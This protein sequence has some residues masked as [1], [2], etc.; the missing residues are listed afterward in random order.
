MTRN[1]DE[2]NSSGFFIVFVS[3]SFCVFGC[4]II[5]SKH[6]TGL[7]NY[8]KIKKTKYLDFNDFESECL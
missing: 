1:S 4:M 3:K 8:D 7:K 6:E 5:S 2:D